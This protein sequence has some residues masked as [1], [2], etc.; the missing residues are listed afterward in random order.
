M[1]AGLDRLAGWLD[2]LSLLA[3]AGLVGRLAAEGRYWQYLNP[4]YLPLT[5][6]AAVLLALLGLGAP[7][8]R[9]SRFSLWRHAAFGLLLGLWLFGGADSFFSPDE[10]ASVP[11]LAAAPRP[12]DGEPSRLVLDGREY[13]KINIGELYGKAEA[14]ETG[15]AWVTRGF[16]IR[17]PDLLDPAGELGLFR[18]SLFCCFADATTV[19]LVVTGVRPEEFRS[20][21]WVRVF[22]RLEPRPLPEALAGLRVQGAF[23]TMIQARAVFRADR[24]EPVPPPE[25]AFMFDWRDD[26]P[27]AY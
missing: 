7:F 18:V 15:G 27:Y 9:V 22:G 13:V 1:R 20:G 8:L 17:H 6:A 26:E 19:G 16:V 24:V 10:D 14:G 25:P 12:A 11:T 2:G 5:A 23:S 21:Q 3:V 4:K